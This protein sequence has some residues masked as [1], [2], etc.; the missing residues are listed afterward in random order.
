M[1]A[2]IPILITCGFF[3][4]SQGCQSSEIDT[5]VTQSPQSIEQA[6]DENRDAIMALPNVVGTGVSRCESELCIKVLVSKDWPEIKEQLD[7]ILGPHLYVV[8]LTD[9]VRA[10]PDAD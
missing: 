8:E 7:A 9:P 4:W 10:L 3:L 2:R 1:P 6:L 5:E